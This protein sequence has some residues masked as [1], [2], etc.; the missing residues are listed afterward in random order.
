MRPAPLPLLFLAGVLAAMPMASAQQEPAPAADDGSSQQVEE[1]DEA[2]RRRMELEDAR[3][4]D[5]GY[6]P[7]PDTWKKEQE[8]IDK[9]PETSRDNIRDQL[10]DVIVENG[11]W[12]PSDALEE[13]PYQP[14][15]EAAADADLA[16]LEQ[17]AW[18]EQI[19]KYHQREAQAFGSYRGP[20]PGPGNP[21]GAEGGGQQGAGQQ[22]E[23]GADGQAGGAAGGGASGSAGTYQPYD[24]NRQR[25]EDAVSTAGVQ[26]SALDFL[27]GQRSPG[28]PGAASPTAPQPA[29]AQ[30]QPEIAQPRQETATASDTAEPAPQEVDPDM[31][32]IIAI[33][34]LDKLE[35]A[36]GA[37]PGDDSE[38]P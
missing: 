23:A 18:D 16:K 33:E 15:A 4:R 28:A 26:E 37:E 27:R 2:Y 29:I 1:S 32:G 25:P 31:R 36:A 9:L 17:E 38:Q 35:G 20:A 30:A 12:E 7:P 8:K 13:Y 5:A 19:E 22:G 11:E 6:N 24:P 3:Q 14:S 10:I 21:D 34:D